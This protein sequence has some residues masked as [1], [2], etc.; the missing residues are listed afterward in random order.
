MF[1]ETSGKHHVVSADSLGEFTN[2]CKTLADHRSSSM[3][4]PDYYGSANCMADVYRMADEGLPRE[5][6][7]AIALANVSGQDREVKDLQFQTRY[8]V[9]G[10]Y[11]DV[12]RYLSGEPECMVD[13][14]SEQVE[15]S[16]P[17]AVLV[18]N[19]A[20]NCNIT[21]AAFTKHGQSLVALAES[22]DASGMQSEIWVDS[23]IKGDNGYTGRF[24]VLAKA[25]GEVF[26]PGAF[27]FTLTHPS[28]FRGMQLNA[29]HDWP[30]KWQT[31]CNV[32]GGYGYASTKFEH[33][34]DY[35]GGAIYI[36]AMRQDSDAGKHL[37]ETL[38]TLGLI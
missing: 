3:P 27:M 11:P 20:V 19:I 2:Y 18:V 25:P 5:G 17:L 9:Q 8:D 37:P 29:M 30:R 24:K 23:T 13:Y 22:I 32:G 36:P 35:P 7:E 34:E 16:Q 21:T 33:P 14:W 1:K 26:D 31:E 10:S 12:A 4:D 38:K 28:F 6:I 15:D